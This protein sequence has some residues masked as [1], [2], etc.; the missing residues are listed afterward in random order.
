MDY[1]VAIAVV[2]ASALLGFIPAYI[3]WRK[4]YPFW[5]WWLAGALAFV[6]TLPIAIFMKPYSEEHDRILMELRRMRPRE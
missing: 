1:A 2:L 3:A 5:A 6:F 4:G